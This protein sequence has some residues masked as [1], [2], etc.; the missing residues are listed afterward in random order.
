MRSECPITENDIHALVDGELTARETRRVA[1]HVVACPK[2]SALAGGTLAGKRLLSPRTQAVEPPADSWQRVVSAL[3]DADSTVRNISWTSR[4][5]LHFDSVPALAV[6]GLMLLVGAGVWQLNLN[7]SAGRGSAQL[8]RAHIAACTN[9]S[10]GAPT[11]S[12]GGAREVVTPTPGTARWAPVARALF[13]VNG[14]LAEQT[15][16]RV[17]RTPVSEFVM[18]PRAF[19]RFGLTHARYRDGEYWY[20]SDRNGSVVA[21]ESGGITHIL[22]GRAGPADLLGLASS[23]RAQAPTGQSF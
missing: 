3:D 12:G 16:Y 10:L 23:R 18:S 1:T 5:R 19:Q 21:W 17:D 2:C 11:R 13:P 7:Y 4:R 14:E 20:S 15:L 6:A 22:V 9:L 8:V